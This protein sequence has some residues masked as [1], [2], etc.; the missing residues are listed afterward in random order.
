MDIPV[1]IKKVKFKVERILNLFRGFLLKNKAVVIRRGGVAVD[2]FLSN[3]S[4][5]YY[6]CGS[7]GELRFFPYSPHSCAAPAVLSLSMF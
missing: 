5:I 1:D 3:V 7:A 6:S 4:A 2:I